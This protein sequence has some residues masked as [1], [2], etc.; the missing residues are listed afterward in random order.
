MRNSGR[1][2]WYEQL[3]RQP[4]KTSDDMLHGEPGSLLFSHHANESL[5]RMHDCNAHLTVV[6]H[7]GLVCEW[8]LHIYVP[9]LVSSNA[10]SPGRPVKQI[11]FWRLERISPFWKLRY[12]MTYFKHYT[13]RAY[14]SCIY[15][16]T[17]DILDGNCAE[18]W[19]R[20]SGFAAHRRSNVK[21]RAMRVRA[22]NLS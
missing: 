8:V 20:A 12:H 17:L 13:L 15:D 11:R 18:E 21:P 4:Q 7:W 10:F 1:G 14:H 5:R 9:S 6:T 22:G 2:R 3:R 19:P 16:A